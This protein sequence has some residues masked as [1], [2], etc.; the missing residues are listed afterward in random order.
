MIE[1]VC[2]MYVDATKD[3]F[4]TNQPVSTT[5]G[6]CPTMKREML[7]TMEIPSTW[8][9]SGTSTILFL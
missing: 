9:L 3:E 2:L 7:S 1:K 4:H 5:D 6:D 8:M